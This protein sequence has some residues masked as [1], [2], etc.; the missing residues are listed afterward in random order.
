MVREQELALNALQ[1][2]KTYEMGR[3]NLDA[4]KELVKARADGEKTVIGAQ[5]K[6]NKWKYLFFIKRSKLHMEN[7]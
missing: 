2:D 4:E 1:F 3:A 7:M 5:L 6:A